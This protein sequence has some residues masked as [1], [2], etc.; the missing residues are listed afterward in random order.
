MS[1]EREKSIVFDISTPGGSVP[2]DER[3]PS[4]WRE[5]YKWWE[6]RERL[7]RHEGIVI[8]PAKE[9]EGANVFE[10]ALKAMEGQIERGMVLPPEALAPSEGPTPEPLSPIRYVYPT[11]KQLVDHFTEQLLARL[12]PYNLLRNRVIEA[13][14]K[15]YEGC[16]AVWCPRCRTDV[17]ALEENIDARMKHYTVKCPLCGDD[18]NVGRFKIVML[19]AQYKRNRMA[20]TAPAFAADEANLKAI[21]RKHEPKGRPTYEA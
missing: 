1:D 6:L 2:P 12:V 4:P 16:P 3:G 7:R 17:A 11:P 15:E 19:L 21:A 18:I 9:G 5:A 20:Q 13:H 8:M 10:Q 14:R